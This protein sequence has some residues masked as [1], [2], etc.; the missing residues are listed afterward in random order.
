MSD[1][2]VRRATA[3]DAGVLA[4]LIDGFA[5]GHPAEGHPRSTEKMHQ[6]FFGNE[7]LAHVLLA[8]KNGHPI[9]FAAWRK[10]YDVFW[11]IFGGEGIGLYL[12]PAH[13]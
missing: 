5:K 2:L 6:A 11:S 9:G 10:T 13:R 7:P 1:L 12:S 4:A 3:S 8:E